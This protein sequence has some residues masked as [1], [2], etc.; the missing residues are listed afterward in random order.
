[1]SLCLASAAAVTAYRFLSASTSRNYSVEP[2]QPLSDESAYSLSALRIFSDVLQRV[3]DS[4]VDPARIIPSRMLYSALESMQEEVPEVIIHA[5]DDPQ[6]VT[7]QVGGFQ[8]TFPVEDVDSLHLLYRRLKEVVGFVERH[9]TRTTEIREVEY[10]CIS[11]AL[12][13][14][15]P[16]SVL[17]DPQTYREMKVGTR[18]SFGGLGIVISVRA[19][20][21]TVISPIDGTPAAKAGIKAGDRIVRIGSE[22]TVNMTLNEAVNRLRGEPGTKVVLHV[23]RNGESQVRRFELTRDVI[24]WKTVDSRVLEGNIGYLRVKHFSRSTALDLETHLGDL[25]KKRVVGLVLDMYN[26]PGGLLEQAIRVADLFLDS[27]VIVT[28]VGNAGKQREEKRAGPLSLAGDL[29]LCVLVNSGSASASEIVAGALKNLDRAV[30]VGESTFGKGSVQVLYDNRDGSALKLTVAQYLTPG[31]LSI[32]STGISPDVRMIPVQ[33]GPPRVSFYALSGRR[34][35]QDLADHLDPFARQRTEDALAELRYLESDRPPDVSEPDDAGGGADVLVVNLARDLL[36]QGYGPKRSRVLRLAREF[37]S[38]RAEV[39][40][41]RI[42]AALEKNGI[43]WRVGPAG[44]VPMLEADIETVPHGGLATAGDSLKIRVTVSNLGVGPAY[45]VRAISSSSSPILRDQEFLFGRIDPGTNRSAE[46]TVAIPPEARSAVWRMRLVFAEEFGHQPPDQHLRVRVLGKPRAIFA[47][48]YQILDAAPGGNGDGLAQWGESL[49]LRLSVRNIGAGRSAETVGT[50]KNLGGPEVFLHRGRGRLN[51]GPLD[52]GKEANGEFLFDLKRASSTQA[53][54]L[55][56]TVF[57][58]ML[59]EGVEQ[60]LIIPVSGRARSVLDSGGVVEVVGEDA[61][62][63]AGTD[64]KSPLL[65][66][67]PRGTVLQVTGRSGDRLRVLHGAG[68][69]GFLSVDDVQALPATAAIP[70][71]G[72]LRRLFH[73]TPPIIALE[74][75]PLSTT[76]QEVVIQGYAK[77]DKRIS[78]FFVQ[79]HS[80]QGRPA[81]RKVFYRSNLGNADPRVL[82]FRTTVPLREGLNTISLVAREDHHVRTTQTI[83]ILREASSRPLTALGPRP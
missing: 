4:Y 42:A 22:S 72:R 83:V 50:L 3:Q 15:D 69:P 66:T 74:R 54:T 47:A 26:N 35:E 46:V 1:V 19:G 81:T 58:N 43:D 29:P 2:R 57:D 17:W 24:K 30:I 41:R 71:P 39:E 7:V 78:D 6:T 9:M 32:Q 37:L 20:V 45:R 21:L 36:L 75:Y 23:E 53:V 64:P 14:L 51:L 12:S 25:K 63:T 67:A 82:G 10:A 65:G 38:T 44:A 48:Q 18:G 79:V 55:L 77:D 49:R 40:Y 27:G 60:R 70:P 8:R 5:Q 61:P 76:E 52:P 59:G 33:V 68:W 34:R 80:P 56:L 13:T 73:L 16:H 31:D 62:V 11:G 28:T